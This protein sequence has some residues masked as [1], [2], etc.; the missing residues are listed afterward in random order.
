MG[1]DSRDYYRPSSFN[2]FSLFPPVIKNL[3][4]INVAVFLLT[5]LGYSIAI[6]GESLA[7]WIMGN[8][9]LVSLNAPH[10]LSFYP[11]QLITYQ[12]L[13]AG[14]S[15]IFW[16]MFALWMFGIEIEQ[17]WGSK[18]FLIFYLISGIGGGLLQLLLSNNFGITLGASGS[19][20][21]VLIAFALF[22]PNR[23][24]YIYFLFPV[25]AKYLIAF[26]VL[27]DLFT[28]G[29]AGMVAKLAHVGGAL[30]GFLFIMLDSGNNF[31][32]GNLFDSVKKMFNSGNSSKDIKQPFR[33]PFGS[34]GNKKDVSEAE[35]YDITDSKSAD[36]FSQ[37]DIDRILDKISESGYQKLTEKEKKILFEASKRK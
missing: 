29:D 20:Y 28:V 4:I 9:A 23:P 27:M 18:K 10:G 26:F 24:I 14:F 16:N 33:R 11:W 32:L 5:Q 35:F 34:N 7:D 12:F 22:F 8:F 30:T 36:S 25:K 1:L 21:G 17:I 19:I 3:L 13:H 37:E 15:H 2:R 6:G 31:S